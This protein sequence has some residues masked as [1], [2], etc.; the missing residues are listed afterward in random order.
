MST[1]LDIIGSTAIGA[2]VILLI[3]SLNIQMSNSSLE[4]FNDTYTQR[5]AAISSKILE[6]NLYKMGYGVDDE[7]ISF[8]DSTEIKFYSDIND[9]G[10]IDTLH[11]YLGLSDSAGFTSNPSDK[12]IYFAINNKAE[13]VSDIVTDFKLTYF[14]ST[15]TKIP[16]KSLTDSLNRSLIRNIQLYIRYESPEP[17]NNSYQA[18]EWKRNIFPKSLGMITRTETEDL[19]GSEDEISE[20][21]EENIDKE[22]KDN[23]EKDDEHGKGKKEKN[24]DDKKSFDNEKKDNKEKKDEHGK[25]KTNYEEDKKKDDNKK[26][27][28]IEKKDNKEKNDDK[29]KKKDDDKSHDKDD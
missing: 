21:E 19:T 2:A 25:K 1:W 11:Y 9:D 24:D 29:D 23:K 13:K 18:V 28:D 4:R 10:Q 22:K 8:A 17:T 14:D 26:S 7:I 5:S 27:F 16:Y 15:G 12:P 6:N 3:L 20:D